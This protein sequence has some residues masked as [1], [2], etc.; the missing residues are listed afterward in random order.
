MKSQ[1]DLKWDGMELYN[2]KFAFH[3]SPVCII[4]I[5]DSASLPDLSLKSSTNVA[6]TDV[7]WENIHRKKSSTSFFH[8][9]TSVS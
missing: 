7:R 8:G 2:T 1:Q 3:I 5:N 9:K 6:N 4:I